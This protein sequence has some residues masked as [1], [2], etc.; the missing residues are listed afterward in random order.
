MY[1]IES[2]VLIVIF[3]A[4]LV[5]ITFENKLEVNKSWIALFIGAIMWIVIAIGEDE[6]ALETAIIHESAEIF[7]LIIFLM[8]AMTIVEMM[9]HFRFFKWIENKLLSFNISNKQLFWILGFTSF[10]ASGLLD[11]LTTTLVMIQIGRHLYI[12]KENFTLYVINVVIAAN[13]GGAM[14]PVGDIT[15]IMLWL[16]GKFTAWQIVLYGFIPSVVAW[17]VPQIMLTRQII[18]ENRI[19]REPKEVL[20]LQWGIIF[21]GLFTFGFAVLVNLFHLP[22]FIGILL[23]MAAAAIVIDYRLKRGTLKKQAGHIVN[24]IKTI[25]MATLNFFIGILLAVGALGHH[26]ILAQVASFIFGDNPGSNPN[27]IV[28]GHVTLGVISS[29]LDNVPLTA[30]V[31]KMLPDGISYSYWVLLAITAGTGGSILVIGSAAGVA[32][33]GQVRELTFMEYFKKGT[34]PAV[35]GYVMAVA[36]WYVVFCCHH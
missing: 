31:I 21:I 23:G 8:G 34:F 18:P 27:L 33:M 11:N 19:G 13:A 26:G 12:K 20:P 35:A 9:G 22:P 14:S 2:I 25:D 32:A 15:T 6:K 4:G 36:A 10:F 17:V 30:A 5:A 24:I 29:I 1:Q 28:T 7:E 3:L 16:S